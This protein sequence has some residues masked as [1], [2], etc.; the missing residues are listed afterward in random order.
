MKENQDIVIL[1]IGWGPV[2]NT[3][4]MIWAFMEELIDTAVKAQKSNTTVVGYL[5]ELGRGTSTHDG[6]AIAVMLH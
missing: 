3:Y 1:F 5:D 2:D 4:K 6:I